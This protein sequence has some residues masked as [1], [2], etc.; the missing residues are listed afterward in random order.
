MN[1]IEDALKTL[2]SGGMIVVTDDENRENEGDLICLAE[3]ITPEQINFMTTHGRGLVC[4]AISEEHGQKLGLNLARSSLNQVDQFK[5]AF[6]NSIDAKHGVTTGISAYDRAQTIKTACRPD[7]LPTDFVSPGHMFP[8]LAKADGVLKRRGHTETAVDLAR[9]CGSPYGGV[10]CEIMHVDGSMMRGVSLSNFVNHYKL[11][12]ITVEN[13]V[14]YRLENEF[15]VTC[16]TFLPTSYGKFR[17]KLFRD[18]LG[19]E[20]VVLFLGEPSSWKNPLIRIHSECLTGDVFSSWRCDCGPQL[21]KSLELIS[22][23]SEGLLVY[24]RQEGRGIGLEAKIKAYH[25]QDQGYDTVDANLALGLPVDKRKYHA[26]KKII[27]D[28]GIKKARILTNNP[29]KIDV[30]KKYLEQCERIPL[31]V[32]ANEIN[33]NYLKVK[34]E[35]LG[36]LIQK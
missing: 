2:K 3:F 36:H 12:F 15:S 33:S 27:H 26:L 7:A 6:T 17:M 4:F 32:G 8:I 19:E 9:L 23:E 18:A 29:D 34:A 16:E 1:C 13:L 21:H 14:E 20:H 35:K 28:F 10:I 31:V 25:L 24:S 11:P 30:A 5:T 22:Q